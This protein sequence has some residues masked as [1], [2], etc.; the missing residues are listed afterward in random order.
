MSRAGI[1]FA[2]DSPVG[3][4]PQTKTH[5]AGGMRGSSSENGASIMAATVVLTLSLPVARRHQVGV[6][7]LATYVPIKA[8]RR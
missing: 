2:T 6:T 5:A 4:P 8:R 3:I 7:P 1:W